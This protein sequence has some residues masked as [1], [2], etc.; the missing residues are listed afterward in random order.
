[1]RISGF[2][3]FTTQQ[4]FLGT[5]NKIE[6]RYFGFYELKF[7]TADKFLTYHLQAVTFLLYITFTSRVLQHCRFVISSIKEVLMTKNGPIN[8]VHNFFSNSPWC[9][10]MKSVEKMACSLDSAPR[11]NF[12]SLTWALMGI[13]T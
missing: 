2:A 1:M 9:K 8:F 3:K 7:V 5:K 13:F 12:W 6:W 10:D 4:W 11:I